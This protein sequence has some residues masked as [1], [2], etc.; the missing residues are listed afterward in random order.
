MSSALEQILAERLRAVAR[1][2]GLAMS[3][4][5]DR[6]GMARSY[7]FRLLTAK[8]SATLDAVQ[9]LAVVLGV[10][11][12]ELL[13]E[14]S[15]RRKGHTTVDPPLAAA[16]PEKERWAAGAKKRQGRRAAKD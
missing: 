5:A 13:G 10:E 14:A 3:H 9:R 16:E 8:S 11:P 6:A 4:V 1:E 12:L 7:V 2:R 15:R